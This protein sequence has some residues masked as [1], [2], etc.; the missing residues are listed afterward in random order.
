M[1]LLTLGCSAVDLI[2]KINELV[3]AY[4]ALHNVTS[5]RD[6]TDKPTIN[7]IEVVGNMTTN[8]LKMGISDCIDFSEIIASLATKSDLANAKTE[9]IGLATASTQEI[10][11]QKLDSNPSSFNEVTMTSDDAFIY[12]YGDGEVK[13]LRLGNLSKNI[14]LSID[15]RK[16]IDQVIAK[17][18]SILQLSGSQDGKNTEFHTK[19]SFVSGTTCLYFN[20]QL[21]TRGMDYIENSSFSIEL[22]TYI[23]T[24]GDV[25]RL[26]AVKQ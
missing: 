25:L 14:S 26:V 10:V 3:A 19:E 17:D 16:A 18:G 2:D 24:E 4:N 6:L 1:E 11:S 13:K 23:P 21:L 5:Y 12:I 8:N 7:G 22:L 15:S 20:G 9:V